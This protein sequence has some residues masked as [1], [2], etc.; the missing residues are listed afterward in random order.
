MLKGKLK[1]RE[2]KVTFVTQ[3][4]TLSKQIANILRRHWP[5]LKDNL[6]QI[7]VFD[8]PPIIAY[9]K[10]RSLG[11]ML[12]HSDIR[13]NK[14]SSKERKGKVGTSP[15]YNC[16]CCSNAQQGNSVFHPRKGN[17]I[18]IK[19][20]YTCSSTYAVYIIKCPCRLEYVGQS[21]RTFRERI[22]EH[23]SAI[24]TGKKEQAV[25]GH[26]IECAHRTI[27]MKQRG[28][29][30]QKKLLY[31]ESFWIRKL[32]TLEPQGLNKEYDLS[33]IFR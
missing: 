18:K 12:V 16:N 7:T 21:K 15:C 5:L 6:P 11:S 24:N 4:N 28:G 20:C 26:F 3:Y 31:R 33:P 10:G 32:E 27:E 9:K 17:P 25:A 1:N 30:K 22:R 19:G 14:D 29:N 13:K 8:R 2:R 23:K